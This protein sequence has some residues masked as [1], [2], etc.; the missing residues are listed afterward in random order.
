M[1]ELEAEAG[2]TWVGDILVRETAPER[3]SRG[4]TQCLFQR[5]EEQEP[6]DDGKVLKVK[7]CDDGDGENTLVGSTPFQPLPCLTRDYHA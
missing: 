2:E 1:R 6:D 4:D 3:R 5:L 7:Q